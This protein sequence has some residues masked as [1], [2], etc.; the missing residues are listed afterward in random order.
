[1]TAGKQI[2]FGGEYL[3]L[4]GD[5]AVIGRVLEH[6]PASASISDMGDASGL[7]FELPLRENEAASVTFVSFGGAS[8][9][10]DVRVSLL[11]EGARCDLKGLLVAT[12]ENRV[13]YDVRV[14]H[15]VGGCRSDQLFKGMAFDSGV[16]RFNG[17]IHVPQG[18]Q[19]T[20]AY[21]ANH[22]LLLSRSARAFSKPQLEIYADD[23][24]CSHGATVGHLDEESLFYMRSRGI[25]EKQAYSL[26][27]TAFAA[28]ALAAI[29]DSSLRDAITEEVFQDTF[30]TSA[31]SKCLSF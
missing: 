10:V 19:K 9:K 21:Q 1:M 16:V 20:E 2:C 17:L 13:E 15:C 6:V 31:Q 28:E 29:S 12:G 14:D 22:N 5:E 24:K 8:A 18:A 3:V 27:C 4:T 30:K 25:S 23:V 11:G 7:K 26:A